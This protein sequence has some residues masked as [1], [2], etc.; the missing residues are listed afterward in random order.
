[1]RGSALICVEHLQAVDLRHVQVEQ[2]HARIARRSL[3]VHALAEHEVQR[4]LAVL[5]PDDLLADAADLERA[6]GQ[7]R[8]GRV[9]VGEQYVTEFMPDPPTRRAWL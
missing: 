1:M 3:G 2:H 4:R 8:V 5:H 7:L 9:V 6:D